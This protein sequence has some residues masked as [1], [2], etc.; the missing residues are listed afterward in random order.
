MNIIAKLIE[1]TGAFTNE[2]SISKA[3]AEHKRLLTLE[4]TSR[5]VQKNAI[6]REEIR[7]NKAR[8]KQ[9]I[10]ASKKAVIYS[11]MAFIFTFVSFALSTLGITRA[12]TFMGLFAS[13]R[14]CLITF[15]MASVSFMLYVVSTQQDYLQKKFAIDSQK[16][17]TLQITVIT[18]SVI[19]NYIFLK[20]V[21]HPV[22]AFDYLVTIVFSAIPDYV[23]VVFGSMSQN[24]KYSNNSY[25]LEQTLNPLGMFVDILKKMAIM[26]LYKPYK[27]TL[28]KYNSI[29]ID[30]PLLVYNTLAEKPLL[31]TDKQDISIND[32]LVDKQ[33]KEVMLCDNIAIAKS[34]NEDSKK[35]ITKLE[36]KT[37]KKATKSNNNCYENA[38]RKLDDLQQGDIVSKQTLKLR[39]TQ[40][41]YNKIREKLKADGLIT[42]NGTISKKA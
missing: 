26:L 31:S 18:I 2:I 32:M 30:N 10:S 28:E 24:V 19:S 4:E 20:D 39:C 21:I 37:L 7:V 14:A 42:V 17:K 6:L 11:F 33:E 22:N 8:A 15:F 16:L 34:T 27:K 23:T 38:I 3:Q 12:R 35:V 13:P 25:Q 36:D 29:V 41:E 5:N 1:K 9:D 40:Y